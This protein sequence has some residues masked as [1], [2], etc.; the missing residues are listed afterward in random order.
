MD[1]DSA[2]R[3]I[4]HRGFAGTAPENTVPAVEY[5]CRHDETDMVEVDVVPTADGT[6]VC[7]HDSHLHETDESRGI[8]DAEGTIWETATET[9][10]DARV[11][12]TDATVPTLDAV[13]DVLPDGVGINVELKHPT[14]PVAPITDALAL[15]EPQRARERWQ[16]FVADVLAVLDGFDGRVLLSS[17]YEGA[18][19]AADAAGSGHPLA[20]ITAE[21]LADGLTTADRYDATAIHPPWQLVTEA[22]VVTDIHDRDMGVNVWTVDTWHRGA[23]LAD[24]GVDGL[25]ADYPGLTAWV[26]GTAGSVDSR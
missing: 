10:L 26:S 17:F 3:V 7:F 1:D 18:L 21:S 9:V 16:P 23:T 5:A 25:I 6:V 19:A 15:A 11:L 22:D 8:T 20:V 2:P 24:A 12:G 14:G 13:L 4:A